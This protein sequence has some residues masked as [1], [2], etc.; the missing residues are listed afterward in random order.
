M[1]VL[2]YLTTIISWSHRS[3]KQ[4]TVFYSPNPQKESRHLS[5]AVLFDLSDNIR[6]FKKTSQRTAKEHI[7]IN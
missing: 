4:L 5:I 6:K 2:H 7:Y 1:V 3:I